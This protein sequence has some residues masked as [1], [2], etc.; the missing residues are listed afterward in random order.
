MIKIL[1][2]VLLLVLAALTARRYL[3]NAPEGEERSRQITVVLVAFA[4]VM[5]VLALTGRLY[6]VGAALA[7]LAPIAKILFT[8]AVGVYRRK[9]INEYAAR[10]EQR[11]PSGKLNEEEALKILGLKK[12]YL[13]DEVIAA[14][15]KLMQ[16]IH[17]DRGGSDYLAAKVNEAKELLL[18]ASS[19]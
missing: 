6:W 19:S 14:H 3:K 12:P 11:S 17:P 5:M 13:H 10:A 9:K 8:M 16:K 15:K 1:V 18:E 7:A 4:I 2:P